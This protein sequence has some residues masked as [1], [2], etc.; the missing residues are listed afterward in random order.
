VRPDVADTLAPRFDGSASDIRF[1]PVTTTGPA[2]AELEEP[3]PEADRSRC[4]GGRR[5]GMQ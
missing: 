3:Q 4:S 1:V 5:R 2:L